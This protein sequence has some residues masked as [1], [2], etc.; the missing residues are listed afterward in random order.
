[1]AISVLKHGI[2]LYVQE[3]LYGRLLYKMGQDFLDIQYIIKYIW[4]VIYKNITI[5]IYQNSDAF[6]TK[7]YNVTLRY[8]NNN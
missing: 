6:Y 2:V 4:Y 5:I 8:K 3:V 7:L 1:M